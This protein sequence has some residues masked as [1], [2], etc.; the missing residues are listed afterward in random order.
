[1]EL[2]MRLFFC[3]IALCLTII[4]LDAQ[5]LTKQLEAPQ[6]DT[7]AV[8]PLIHQDLRAVLKQLEELE[9]VKK[10]LVQRVVDIA[11]SHGIKPEEIAG[12]TQDHKILKRKK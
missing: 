1:M 5:I 2:E 8:D 4:T 6:F 9:E 7:V 11:K 3:T 10:Q 12:F